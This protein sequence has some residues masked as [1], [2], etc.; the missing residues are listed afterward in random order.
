MLS[1]ISTFQ[2][3]FDVML[4]MWPSLAILLTFPLIL[5][6]YIRYHYLPIHRIFISYFFILYAS[7]LFFAFTMYPFP[8]NFF[9]YCKGHNHLLIEYMP[10]HSVV[11]ILKVGKKAVFQVIMNIVFFIPLG[12]FLRNFFGTKFKTSLILI[13]SSSLL[14]EIMQLTHIFGLLPCQYRVFDVD[15]LISNTLG[16]C[17]GLMIAK[18]LPDFSQTSKRYQNDLNIKPGP[19]ER[20]MIMLTEFLLIVIITLVT[21]SCMTKIFALSAEDGFKINTVFSLIILFAVEVVTP[22]FSSGRTPLAF[23]THST[24]DNKS[25]ST[26]RKIIYYLVRFFV[27]ALLFSG[28][29]PLLS[30]V[31]CIIIPLT[32]PI[33]RIPIFAYI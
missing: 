27:L 2:L 17:L 22:W 23:L 9:E 29:N 1:Y 10:L 25:R 3:S 19:I 16:G 20:L 6:Q 31:I 11:D 4:W 12:C 21:S 32:Y 14:I 28:F 24:I 33:K 7:G 26:V 13:F 30:V 15:D 5:V 18:F 8:N